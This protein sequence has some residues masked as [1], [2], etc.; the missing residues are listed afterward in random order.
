MSNP[1]GVLPSVT[2]EFFDVPFVYRK[3]CDPAPILPPRTVVDANG[4]WAEVG[5]I[6]PELLSGN[7]TTGWVDAAGEIL[8]QLQT[9]ED[10][11]TWADDEMTDAAVTG[12]DNLNGTFTFWARRVEPLYW[13]AVMIDLTVGTDR[14]GKSITGIT[15]FGTP[16]TTGMTYPYAMP[17][18][19]ARLQTDLRAAGYTGATVTTATGTLAARVNNHI[20]TGTAALFVTMSGADVTAVKATAA[21]S[22]ISLPAYPYTMPGS[23]ATLQTDLRAAGYTGAVVMLYQDP[24]QIFIPDQSATAQVRDLVLAITP[25]DPAAVY[26]FF[27][28]YTGDDPQATLTSVPSNLRSLALAPLSEAPKAFFRVKR[29]SLPI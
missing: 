8:W 12:I 29:T 23:R 9:S 24:W 22:T 19:A 4:K 13:Q 16:V 21:G 2:G 20:S 27:G 28:T 18:D 17:A 25:S 26:N 3:I 1:Y 10:L 5:F 6:A 7:A 11:V 15:R 14:Q